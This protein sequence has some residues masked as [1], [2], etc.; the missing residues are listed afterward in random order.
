[1]QIRTIKMG[2]EGGGGAERQDTYNKFFIMFSAV[3]FM[4]SQSTTLIDSRQ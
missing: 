2:E 3:M 4:S 1:M